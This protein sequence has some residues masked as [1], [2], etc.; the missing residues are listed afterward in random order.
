MNPVRIPAFAA[1]V[2]LSL[3]AAAPALANEYAGALQALAADQLAAWTTNPDLIAA[4]R[5][6]NAANAG[7]S[8]ADIDALDQAWR[9]EVGA[10]D[11]P[12][13]AAVLANPSS[14]WLKSQKD[15]AGGLI[16]EVFVMDNRGL[17]VAQSDVTSDYWQ[18]DEDKWS[19]TFGAGATAVH[20]GEVELDESTQTYQS[21]VS[22][23][24][25]DPDTGAPIGAVTFGINLELLP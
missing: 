2:L 11:Q 13:I 17:N 16:T 4:I 21:Q 7:L 12:T 10:G 19:Q 18:G 20:L 23:A 9:A 6:Q 22:M 5:A 8:Q 14:A 3:P 15:A 1:A 24:I 25:T